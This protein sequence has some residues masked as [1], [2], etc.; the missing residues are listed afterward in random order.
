MGEKNSSSQMC[1]AL[2][3]LPHANFALFV[4]PVLLQ[5]KQ[6]KQ[7]SRDSGNK[8]IIYMYILIHWLW[9]F[10]VLCVYDKFTNLHVITKIHLIFYGNIAFT[11]YTLYT[12]IY[13]F[14]NI[15]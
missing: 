4:F 3:W 14:E 2:P 1:Q 12:S 11:L 13:P 9:D 7:S 15:S 10:Y 6:T 8:K 5:K